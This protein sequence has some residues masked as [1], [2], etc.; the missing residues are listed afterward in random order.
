MGHHFVPQAYLRGFQDP[1]KP[2]FIW[3]QSRREASPSSASIKD[4]AQSR[5]FYD[6][7]TEGL[8]AS[9]VPSSGT[10]DSLCRRS[11]CCSHVNRRGPPPGL[12]PGA[13]A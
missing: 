6:P 4:V 5:D 12:F 1:L 7:E 10:V 3:V 13:E 2:G 8:L 9:S 11:P